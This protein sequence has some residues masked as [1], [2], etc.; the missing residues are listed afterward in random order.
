MKGICLGCSIC[1]SK[2]IEIELKKYLNFLCMCKENKKKEIA[3]G[4][5]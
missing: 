4:Q 3:E 1:N 2:S 5:K